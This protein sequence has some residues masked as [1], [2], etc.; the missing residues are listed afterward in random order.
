MAQYWETRPSAAPTTTEKDKS[1]D[2][3]AAL[4]KYGK[5]MKDFHRHR[6][7]LAKQDG[8]RETDDWQSELRRYLKVLAKDVSPKTDV[9]AWWQVCQH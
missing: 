3:T 5:L 7:R 6:E 4:A 1:A 9:V 8:T 2:N